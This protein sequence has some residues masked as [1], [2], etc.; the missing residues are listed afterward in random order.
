M[1]RLRATLSLSQGGEKEMLAGLAT[2]STGMGDA[3]RADNPPDAQDNPVAHGGSGGGAGGSVLPAPP[4][5]PGSLVVPAVTE[6]LLHGKNDVPA[7]G[8]N[9][10]SAGMADPGRVV[11]PPT[12][13][14][15][16]ISREDPGTAAGPNAPPAPIRVA[17]DEPG[18]NAGPDCLPKGKTQEQH[19]LAAQIEISIQPVSGAAFS[20]AV[21]SAATVGD[22]KA[23][24]RSA[25]G[26]SSGCQHLVKTEEPLDDCQSLRELFVAEK[27]WLLFLV[28]NT[29]NSEVA[30]LFVLMQAL[31]GLA[32]LQSWAS[33]R[34]DMAIEEAQALQLQGVRMTGDHVMELQLG[35]CQLNGRI[36]GIQWK[37]LPKLTIVNLNE[38]GITGDFFQ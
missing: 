31:E 6:A 12:T 38:N 2:A 36:D 15:N 27:R 10:T 29:V 1:F 11:N 8:A 16:L 4:S 24:I 26:L 23:A 18:L 37:M 22:V 7:T 19:D 3:G 14:D 34:N 20:V 13:Q 33:L 30:V 5:A 35:R 9:A 21:S 32:A 17:R 28:V 25:K